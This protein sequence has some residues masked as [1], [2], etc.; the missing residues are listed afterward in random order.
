MKKLYDSDVILAKAAKI[1]YSLDRELFEQKNK[2]MG[3]F[4]KDCQEAAV[5]DALLG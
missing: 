1:V 2:L 5:P 4:S 3:S